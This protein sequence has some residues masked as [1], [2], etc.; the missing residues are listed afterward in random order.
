MADSR[1]VLE[2][3]WEEELGDHIVAATWRAD[4][5]AL[6]VASI[7]GPILLADAAGAQRRRCAGH[8]GGTLGVAWVPGDCLASTGQDGH[9]RLWDA[10]AGGQVAAVAAGGAW[11]EQLAVAADGTIATGSGR[12]VRWWDR[13]AGLLKEWAP[14]LSTAAGI[15]WHHQR[16]QL[17]VSHYGGV[18]LLNPDGSERLLPWTGSQLHLAWSPTGAW[19]AAATQDRAVHLWRLNDGADCEMGGFPGKVAGLAWNHRGTLLAT[20]GGD[21]VLLWDCSGAGPMGRSAVRTTDPEAHQDYVT[22][23]AFHPRSVLLASGDRSGRLVLW[24]VSPRDGGTAPRAQWRAAAGITALAWR[25]DGKAIAVGD[26][27]GRVSLMRV[28]AP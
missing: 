21:E 9:L 4:G 20:A 7:A 14:R 22:A 5:S 19:L 3:V 17:A 23:L 2:A 12:V 24:S 25:P 1:E 6:A 16:R 10:R 11:V 27:H 28:P 8:G 26:A 15:H 18:S 13:T